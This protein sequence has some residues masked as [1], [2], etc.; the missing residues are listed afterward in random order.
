METGIFESDESLDWFFSGRDRSHRSLL[1]GVKSLDTF[2]RLL[3]LKGSRHT[4]WHKCTGYTMNDW[5]RI[6]GAKR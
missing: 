1:Q 4:P 3:V 2:S 5:A 6:Y